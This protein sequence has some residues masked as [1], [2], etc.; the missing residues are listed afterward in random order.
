MADISTFVYTLKTQKKLDDS[1][2]IV[3]SRITAGDGATLTY[4][5]NGIPLSYG[6]LG[7]PYGQVDVVEVADGNANGSADGKGYKWDNVNKT[8]RVYSSGSEV[9][10]SSTLSV[11]IVVMAIGF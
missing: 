5:A 11:D 9:A 10:A 6:K 8:I 4:P 7:F 2:K 3:T 1:R